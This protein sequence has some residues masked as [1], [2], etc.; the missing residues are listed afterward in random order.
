MKF[1]NQEL[2]LRTP[3]KLLKVIKAMHIRKATRYLKVT[4]KKQS[5][6]F[7]SYKW[8]HKCTKAKQWGWTWLMAQKV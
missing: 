7:Q 6:P 1:T 5:V 4:L 3:E 2:A 8:C